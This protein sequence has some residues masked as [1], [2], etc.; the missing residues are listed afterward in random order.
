MLRKLLLSLII[1]FSM[2][3]YGQEKQAHVPGEVLFQLKTEYSIE[4]FQNKLARN[5]LFSGE[6]FNL[7]LISKNVNI[8]SLKFDPNSFEHEEVLHYLRIQKE[9]SYAQN[10]RYV[11]TRATTP[12]DP[13]FTNQWHLENTGQTGGTIG[14]DISAT[15]AWDITTGGL[16][17]HGDTIVV[18]VIE[19]Q[20]ANLTLP[21]LAPNAWKNIHEIPNNGIDDDNNGYV[22]DYLGWNIQNSTDDIGNGN[23]GTQ[24][25]S[26]IGAKGNNNSG[27]SGIN[28]D[29]QIMMIK[30]VVPASESSVLAA[31]DY[32]LTMRK[33]YNQSNGT[34]GAFVVVTNASWGV[35][36]A[37]TASYPLWCAFYDSLGVHGILNVGAT[38]NNNVN[39]DIAGDMPTM[40]GSD[41]LISV[42]ATDHNDA[43]NFSGYGA[44]SIDLAAPGQNVHMMN[45]GGSWGPST[46]TSFACPAVAGTVALMYSIDCPSFMALVKSDPA[47][48]VLMV[49]QALLDGVD[50]VAGLAGETVTGGRLN[51]FEALNELLDQCDTNECSYAYS[52]QLDSITDTT[53]RIDWDGISESYWFYFKEATASSFD[54]VQVDTNFVFLDTL[55]FCTEY[56]FY[57]IT[58]C[59]TAFSN[60]TVT[61]GFTS[62]GCCESP[63]ILVDTIAST[64]ASFYW[65]PIYSANDYSIRYRILGTST[66]TEQTGISDTFHLIS[67]LVE[68]EDYE[69]QIQTNCSQITTSY[70]SSFEF[71]TKGC[72]AC[73]DQQYCDVQA[74][75]SNLEWIERVQLNWMDYT[76]GDN[77][78]Y[79]FNDTVTTT[80]VAG[81]QYTIAVTPGYAGFNFT[82][83]FGAWIDFD[84]NGV[85]DA[86]ERI[87][88]G[89]ENG[90]I[91][92]VFTVPASAVLGQTKMRITMVGQSG[93]GDPC[94]SIQISGEIEDYCIW[95]SDVA[96]TSEPLNETEVKVYPNPTNGLIQVQL[97]KVSANNHL[98]IYDAQGKL[99]LNA[100]LNDTHNQLDISHL[101]NGVYYLK[102]KNRQAIL[103]IEKLIKL[104]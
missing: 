37:D 93:G 81:D 1:G 32:P 99:V 36:N 3:S 7:R 30:G 2:F 6:L 62:D 42:T 39:V 9:I 73:Y 89:F 98:E 95:I 97:N 101:Q 76:S 67:G 94:P 34:Q 61:Y 50:P 77:N 85:F 96:S 18:C 13:E 15:D 100:N 78:G 14:S 11:Q 69:I 41:Y 64:T 35:D 23:H 90:L 44:V 28:W 24:V 80:L 87:L 88:A 74:G 45:A 59:D 92:D 84:Q 91:N 47:A 25:S 75:N 102:I 51:T 86:S 17:A 43:R 26:V 8:F 63:N 38:A 21:E 40:C 52:I 29:I 16:T 19:E 53:A 70:S 12:N 58:D 20:G 5:S 57:L 33:M 72:G 71:K 46:G 22:D 83:N 68:C 31:Y 10:N 82:E 48:A 66:W 65:D 60:P 4:A 103:K 104:E 79:L 56:D 55:V 27:G 54:S 49:R